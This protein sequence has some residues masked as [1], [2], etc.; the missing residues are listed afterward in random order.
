MDKYRRRQS[1]VLISDIRNFTAV[2][3]S[4]RKQKC[5]GFL[6]FMETYYSLGLKL[7]ALVS[8]RRDYF[9]NTSGDG[10]LI[11]FLDRSHQCRGFLCGL[12]MY[13]LMESI[14]RDF[15]KK[16]GTG[17]SFGIGLESGA[18][19]RIIGRNLS[20]QFVTY[21]GSVI[22]VASRIENTTKHYH[23]TK[24][25]IGERLY[26]ELV[27]N[28]FHA[29]YEK[30]VKQSSR[31]L[32]NYHEIVNHHNELNKLTQHLMLF[33]LFEHS[34]TGVEES[35]PL[36][37]LSPTLADIKK[38]SFYQI[39]RRLSESPQRYQQIRLFLR[40]FDLHTCTLPKNP[41][42]SPLPAE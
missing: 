7:A 13:Q 37:R 29:Q 3:E 23:R 27:K 19:H 18:V 41:L 42:Q 40:E 36:F 15:N 31:R 20:R 35:I 1:T 16:W 21:L 38:D 32:K 24:M 11:I 25:I 34:L 9:I 8:G 12:L 22:N 10:I 14:C 28:L 30:I 6:E 39:V 33:Y 17:V 4:F 2:F 5:G 26:R